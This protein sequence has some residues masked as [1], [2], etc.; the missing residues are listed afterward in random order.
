MCVCVREKEKEN[1]RKRGRERREREGEKEREKERKRE[2][3]R[4]REREGKKEKE[5]TP[6]KHTNLGS[7]DA[8]VPGNVPMQYAR[9]ESVKVTLSQSFSSSSFSF[10]QLSFSS[11]LFECDLLAEFSIDFWD[12]KIFFLFL[13]ILPWVE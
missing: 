10:L 6:H 1:K 11:P 12:T 13:N 7:V 2:R 3:K 5:I 8:R 9:A 4:E